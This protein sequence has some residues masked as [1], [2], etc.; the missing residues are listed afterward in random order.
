M[1]EDKRKKLDPRSIEM[2]FVGYEPGSKGYR[3][4]NSNTRAVV[5]L[6]DVTFDERSFPYQEGSLPSAPLVA[7]PTVLDGPVTVD[8]PQS[9]QG[10]SAPPVP[11]LPVTPPPV[12]DV[13]TTIFQ[14]PPSQP[15]S[16]S[17]LLR[18]CTVRVCRCPDPVL[19]GP[20]FE[21]PNP[22]PQ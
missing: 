20:A 5:L 17:P 14:T 12:L 15:T 1:P 8:Y 10:G 7:Q 19:P 3:L 11:Q 13:D 16:H 4:W 2:T 9:E 21:L 22:S 6:H 18:A